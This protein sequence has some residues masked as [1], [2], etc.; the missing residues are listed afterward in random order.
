MQILY[1]THYGIMESLGQSQILPYLRGLASR[2]YSITILSFEKQALLLD[3]ER[4]RAQHEMLQRS[5]IGWLPHTYRSGSSIP[6]IIRDLL[7]TSGEI[8]RR[9][10]QGRV[11]L[12]HCRVHLPFLMSWYASVTQRKPILFDFRGFL[13]EEYVDAGLWRSNSIKFRLTKFLERKMTAR[14]SAMVVLTHS[15]RDYFRD[16]YGTPAQKLFVIPCCVDLERFTLKN[17]LLHPPAGRPLKIV[18]SGS[19]DGRYDIPAMLQFFGRL[20]EKRPGS[21][22]TILSTG[23]QNKVKAHIQNAQLPA[24]TVT[25]RSLPHQQVPEF[26][27]GQDLGLLFLRGDLGLVATSPTKLGEYLACGLGVVAEKGLGDFAGILIEE[28]VGCLAKSSQPASWE[29]AINEAIRLCDQPEIRLRAA[30]TAAK[31]YSLP[32]GVDT[33]AQAY[34]YAVR[35][36]HAGD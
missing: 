17:P 19:T 8:S 31:Y 12:I 5:E 18:Y 36:H 25:V 28:D 11:D 7:R 4:L 6:N 1:I 16:I 2:D 30:Q 26:L 34:E 32:K 27:S 3:P 14:C 10:R 22:L 21:H 24:E 13:A 9:C 20:N 23:D 35:S 15:V 29:A 33:Y